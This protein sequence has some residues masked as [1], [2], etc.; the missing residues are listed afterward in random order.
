MSPHSLPNQLD[1]ERL[2]CRAV[3]E[4]PAGSQ[5]KFDFNADAGAFEL[6]R[7]LP[8]GL[9]FPLDFGFVP[10]TLGG[11]GD[12][13]DILVLTEAAVPVGCL[14]IARLLGV[15]EAEQTEEVDGRSSTLRNDRIVARLAESRSYREVASLQQLG[16]DF[17]T[18]LAG[19]FEALNE[20]KGNRFRVLAT[21]GPER[22]A[23]LVA[24]GSTR[25]TDQG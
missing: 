21:A 4:S 11:D 10:S 6:H 7:M 19:F 12:P 18:E 15:I 2:T 14:L 22:A 24:H 3:I 8:A 1:R 9:V 17:V 25:W 16:N 20:L 5:A 23:E 13:L